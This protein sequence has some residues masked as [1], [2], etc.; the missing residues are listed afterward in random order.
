M[1]KIS[2]V[3]FDQ[4]KGDSNAELQRAVTTIKAYVKNKD[5]HLILNRIQTDEL[6]YW[7]IY[8]YMRLCILLQ[9]QFEIVFDLQ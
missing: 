2:L 6:L 9:I 5:W 7:N 1:G 4:E 8:I 3:R